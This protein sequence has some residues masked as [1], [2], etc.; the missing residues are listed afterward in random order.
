MS[1]AATGN[2]I[3]E[4]IEVPPVRTVIR[5][6][7][8][9]ESS[10]E[11]AG[12]FVF[13]SEVK[14]HLTVIAE[15]LSAA[16]GQGY[17]L[18]GDFGSGKSHFLAALYTW[19]SGREGARRMSADH[20]ALGRAQ[21]SAER[22][23]PVAVSLI[24][25]RSQTTLE[26]IVLEGIERALAEAGR[27]TPLTPLSVFLVRLKELLKSADTA[28]AFLRL[29]ADS[30]TG[31]ADSS[32]GTDGPSGAGPPTAAPATDLSAWITAHPREAYTL[33]LRLFKEQ[34]L[35]APQAL[36]ENR[37]DTF[38]RVY[39]ELEAA[40]FS[41][42]MLLID[43]LS[44]FLRSKPTT[45]AQNE[46]ART[47]QFLGE[48]SQKRPLWIVAAVQESVESTGDYDGTTIRKIKDRF[49]IK[50]AL[51]TVHIRALVSERLVRKK[52]GAEEVILRIYED[53]RRQ[54]STF[55][56]SFDEFRQLYPVHPATIALL[57][58]LGGLFSQHRG[59]V[60]FVCSRIAGDPRRGIPS[61]LERPQRELLGPDSIFEH[62]SARLAEFSTY[63][64]YPRHIVPHL[65]REIDRVI[66]DGADRHLARRIVRMLV[67]YSIHPT[68][69]APT[70]AR[71]AELASCSLDA[72][73]LSARFVAEALLDPL[74]A[75]SR[76]LR[77]VQNA[78]TNPALS[79][80]EITRE[81]DSLKVLEARIGRVS[82]EISKR[83][84]RLLGEP[85][86]QLPE[87]DS[88]PGAAVGREGT[89]REIDWNLSRRRALVRFLHPQQAPPTDLTSE[90]RS[91]QCD[92]ALLL[93]LGGAASPDGI[94][95]P[96]V[97]PPY[98]HAAI[99]R[100]PLPGPGNALDTLK[101]YLAVRLLQQELSPDNPADAPLIP[102]VAERTA[103]LKPA[104][105]QAA[106]EAFYAGSFTDPGI[107]V[108]AAVRQLRRFDSLLEAAG[109]T[110]LAARYPRFPEV[111]PRRY[112]PSP[113][114]YQQL[115]E[116][117]VIPGI[118]ALSQARQLGAAVDGLA[119]PLGLVEMK[120]SSY[121]FSPDIAG[122]PLLV[123]FFELLHP[124][125]TAALPEVLEKLMRGA[126][127]LPK[128]T[129]LFLIASLAAGGLV[130][131]RRGGRAVAL[132]FLN[133]QNLERAEE[134]ALGELIGERDRAT[135]IEE[136][137]FL[138]STD[139][140]GSFGL[141]QQR[142]A[143]KEVV[144]FRGSAEQLS[145]D[146]LARLAQ[147][148][149]YSSFR[150]FPFTALEE[151]LNALN[152]LA[153]EIR[154]SYPAKEGLEKF[155][156]AWR[157]CGLSA[158]DVQLLKGLDRFLRREAEKFVFVHHYL[159]HEAVEKAG[160]LDSS[161]GGELEALRRR[162]LE[163]MADPLEGVIPDEGAEL[164]NL[165]S[166]F[167]ERYI[168]LYA[169]LHQGYYEAL[170]PPALAKNAARALETL[171]RLAGIE[172][173]DRPPGLDRF[174]LSLSSPRMG[175][176]GRQVREELMRAPVCGCGFLPGQTASAAQVKDPQAEI[177]RFLQEYLGIL[178][179]PAVLE[180]LGSHAFAI[181]DL[182]AK[183]AS[184]L[185]DLA[186]ALG[187]GSL[188][189]SVLVGALDPGVAAELAEALKGSVTLRRL[190]LQPLVRRLAGRRLPAEKILEL[191]AEWLGKSKG[192]ELIAVEGAGATGGV[193]GGGESAG[194][195]PG[196]IGAA[197]ATVMLDWWAAAN[198]NIFPDLAA[199]AQRRPQRFE[200]LAEQLERHY[201]SRRL[202][203]Q[204]RRLQ[205]PELLHFIRSEP[206]H[207]RAI[208]AAWQILAERVFKG[209]TAAS[210]AL[211]SDQPLHCR[212]VDP[213]TASRTRELLLLLSRL[214]SILELSFPGR[215][216]LRL[217]LET[218]LADPWNGA[219]LQD[220]A[221]ELLRDTAS[222][223][224]RWLA[225]LMPVESIDLDRK[226]L[227]VLVDGVPPDLWLACMDLIQ[228][229]PKGLS[230]GWAR[231]EAEPQTVPATASLL[232]LEGEPLET[233]EAR[234]VPY[235]LPRAQE[236]D[237]LEQFLGSQ[238]SDR[239]V[240][241]RISSL[242]R[243][244]HQGAFKLAE[245]AARLRHLLETKLPA[246]L[247]YCGKENRQ[248]ILTTDHGLSLSAGALS[249]G[250]G[251]VYERAIFRAS[252]SP[253]AGAPKAAR[254]SASNAG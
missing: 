227:V 117:F 150:G 33:G 193:S 134:I 23:L 45:R 149:E 110:V 36:V 161:P 115:L 235:L 39:G 99:W 223:G 146:A 58:G 195:G 138:S 164:D 43:E 188:S 236:E 210:E 51:S 219:E 13:T 142:D 114:I 19:L 8:G 12:S 144:S 231:L 9:R 38:Q 112:T 80:Y 140:F 157:A 212:H 79:V 191:V 41:G 28:R 154:V 109:Q 237:S 35:E 160:S 116:S 20:E 217:A 54:F 62:F 96:E 130:T 83:D 78:E 89:A 55:D 72:P 103:R 18:Q 42:L 94:Q 14:A 56:S 10:A 248:L 172:A 121:V 63:N 194:E 222:L 162:I 102:L 204:L 147:R 249:H 75:S 5:L 30:G 182:K 215:L 155:L 159:R 127:G 50:L 132:E 202:A 71:L 90:L 24:D 57:D 49:P 158:G 129:A 206:L 181:Q 29:A 101:E 100:I 203:E 177:D 124:S 201:P 1:P 82:E 53:Y 245:M 139:E 32:G 189:A 229:R 2:T 60:D 26:S 46:D 37:K 135:L 108:D 163:L 6:E 168:P 47:L 59:I 87:S 209:D 27:E 186:T 93:T 88:W 153:A 122:H 230:A 156:A 187:S 145:T 216:S 118:L 66:S 7:E 104:A 81:E 205:P 198:A 3:G 247:D 119:V 251:G 137:G 244:A 213:K 240:V 84:S 225:E 97:P 254:K 165:F 218:F 67:L 151:K 192:G 111:A 174:L 246:L 77:K 73:E 133:L 65:D 64:I 86:L 183:V 76:F 232:G 214:R 173:L 123:F 252:W 243:G 169:G 68:A 228:A 220:R 185:N 44:E 241:L 113:R 253:D 11:I 178:K 234:G 143:W 95:P 208:Q 106:L 238:P 136:C 250:A 170:R 221:A 4:L 98:E 128:D 224:E 179:S 48:L 166:A 200:E 167:R 92:F 226:A 239:A 17:F 120:R 34:G 40:G 31:A 69:K 70:A 211:R 131:V 176:C 22:V 197:G 171:R 25:Y 190:E 16:R 152:K 141:R 196:L 233:L 207:T 74:A 180:A 91:R 21:A 85:L 105:A 15:A 107:R 125:Q 148:R 199:A 242:D 184:Q 175:Q 52:A 61:I 126:F